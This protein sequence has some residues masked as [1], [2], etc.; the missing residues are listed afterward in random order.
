MLK[1]KVKVIGEGGNLPHQLTIQKETIAK[2]NT[3]VFSFKLKK[4]LGGNKWVEK[5]D[6]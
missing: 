3:N 2:S 5:L 4:I 6:N 1:L